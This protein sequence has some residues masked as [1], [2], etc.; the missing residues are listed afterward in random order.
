MDG[1][2]KATDCQFASNWSMMTF[3]GTFF[4]TA[5]ITI[6]SHTWTVRDQGSS[7][8]YTATPAATRTAPTD[9]RARCMP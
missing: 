1:L 4:S 9:G 7:S 3:C 2:T 5:S 6:G 8:R